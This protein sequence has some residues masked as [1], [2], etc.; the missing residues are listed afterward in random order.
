MYESWRRLEIVGNRAV[1]TAPLTE[2][3]REHADAAAGAQFI[4]FIEQVHHIET[5]FDGGFF[6]DLDPARQAEVECFVGMEF[7]R[8]GK[9]LP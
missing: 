1:E 5:Y 2:L 7:L 9:T 4:D 6:R 8:V 3:R